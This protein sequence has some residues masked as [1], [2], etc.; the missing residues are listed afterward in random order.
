MSEIHAAMGLAG[1]ES[2]E[3]FEAV[4]RAR[5]ERYRAGLSGLPGIRLAGF[6]EG[7]RHNHQYVVVEVDA[8]ESGTG[9]DTLMEILRAENVLARRYFFPG[10]HR[11]EPYASEA[12]GAWDCLLETERLASRVLVLPTGTG[13]SEA[14]VDE[15]CRI[16]G[17]ALRGAAGLDQRRAA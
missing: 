7:E 5:Y 9:R 13:V 14:D 15:I 6:P 4:N 10:C 2:L 1:L 3:E 16:V 11:M 12:P 17:V 8:E